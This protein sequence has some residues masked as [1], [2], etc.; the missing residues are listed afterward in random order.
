VSENFALQ[1]LRS[2]LHIMPAILSTMTEFDMANLCVRDVAVVTRFMCRDRFSGDDYTALYVAVGIT[3]DVKFVA[4]ITRFV[5]RRT[6]RRGDEIPKYWVRRF[7]YSSVYFY[8][9]IFVWI[10][11]YDKRKSNKSRLKA[12]MRFDYRPHVYDNKCL[13][14]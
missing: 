12:G 4:N 11:E 1:T 7:K 9:R 14:Y 10:N 6:L 3:E 8:S 2:C 5:I 13:G